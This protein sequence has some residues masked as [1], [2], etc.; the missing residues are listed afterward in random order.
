[1]ASLGGPEVLELRELPRPEPGPGEVLIEVALAGVNFADT[2]VRS[3]DYLA[4]TELPLIPG[5]E[6][7]GIRMDTGA[8]VVSLC[9]R[10]GYAEYVCAPE[11]HTY[12]IPDAI[13]DETALGLFLVGVTAWHL[14]RTAGRVAPGES[15][16]VGSAAGGIGSVAVQLG[17]ALGAGRVIATASSEAKLALALEL[18]A[19][20]AV[21][22]TAEGLTERLREAN[23]GRR[24][25]VV[26]EAVGGAV[27]EASLAA[28]A[29]FG[30]IVTYGISGHEQNE[31][32]TGALL[33]GSQTVAGF[34]LMHC[35]GRPGMIESA[36]SDLYARAAAG[37]LHVRV[38]G[39][40]PLA[41]AADAQVDLAARRTT[42]K[43]LIDVRG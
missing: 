42:G 30:R 38:G 11:A 1:M 15:V 37:T 24:V 23:G 12:P 32:R 26:F 14:Y 10:G 25:D 27:F 40:Y 29:P 3:G 28:L 31:V 2:H 18:G 39:T 34:W 19:D 22:G 33:R 21:L 20:V 35:L 9:G 17:H 36:L 8:R 43:L 16:V 13:D 7:A 5:M 41:R 4:A 6:V